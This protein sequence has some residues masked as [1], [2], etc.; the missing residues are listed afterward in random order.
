MADLPP[1]T[2]SDLVVSVEDWLPDLAAEAVARRVAERGLD[3]T[4]ILAAADSLA[5]GAMIQL[6]RDGFD[7]PGQVSVVGMDDLPNA[8][9]HSPPLT[10][11]RIPM[12]EIGATAVDILCEETGNPGRPR[13]AGRT[14]LLAG[15]TDLRDIAGSGGARS[16]RLNGSRRRGR[17]PGSLPSRARPC[18]SLV[19]GKIR[20]TSA[21]GDHERCI[22][23][24]TS[25]PSWPLLYPG[26]SPRLP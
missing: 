10:S 5:G 14:G 21:C 11:V 7:V 16:R 15:G 9:F 19:L 20:S 13:A 8:V 12:R 17:L 23:R 18:A 1:E 24:N 6:V 22:L 4:A 2:T 3:F 26:N 25:L